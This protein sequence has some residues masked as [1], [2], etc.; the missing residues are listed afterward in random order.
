MAATRV[1]QWQAAVVIAGR[2]CGT[3]MTHEGGGMTAEGATIREGYGLPQVQLGSAPTVENGT[4]TRAFRTER[5]PGLL[6]FLLSKAGHGAAVVSL[7]VL[8][9]DGFAVGKPIVRAGV[10]L[11]VTLPDVDVQGS[12]PAMISIEIGYHG[13]II[14]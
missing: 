12:D 14:A 2:D 13:A 6:P 4:L 3:W 1:D 10:L 11:N 9:G 5:E 7:Q 8:D